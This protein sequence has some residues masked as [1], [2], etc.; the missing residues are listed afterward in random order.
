MLFSI[1]SQFQRMNHGFLMNTFD[2]MTLLSC[3]ENPRLWV[4][5]EDRRRFVP[6]PW[7]MQVWLIY[8]SLISR[9]I[10]GQYTKRHLDV[11]KYQAFSSKII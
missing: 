2:P 5:K 6:R 10:L 11:Y 3:M 1:A 7:F 4:M 8:D 9:D